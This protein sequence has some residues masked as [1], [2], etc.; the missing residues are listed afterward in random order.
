MVENN[1]LHHLLNI[2]IVKEKYM[3]KELTQ[4][5]EDVESLKF[6]LN[7]I[8]RDGI[9]VG[10]SQ[11]AHWKDG[12]QYVGTTGTTLKKAIEEVKQGKYDKN[13]VIDF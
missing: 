13:K 6:H 7:R 4:E 11:F 8:F 2:K 5:E 10:I 9:I 1:F 3:D 12:I